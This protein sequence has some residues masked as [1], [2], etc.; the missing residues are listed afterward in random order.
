MRITTCYGAYLKRFYQSRASL[1]LSPYA[2]Q[3]S[4]WL[5]DFYGWADV[6]THALQ[7]F[8]YAG[9]EP[10]ANADQMQKA[11]AI[12]NDVRYREETWVFDILKAQV[13]SFA[14]DILFVNDHHTFTAP[15]IR[16]LR[17]F[18][19]SIRIIIG[20][21][22]AP[23]SDSSSLRACD[24]VLSNI[25]SL[26][27]R[28]RK[29]GM[30]AE[31]MHHAFDPR[32]LEIL[33]E[34]YGPP[35]D[36]S[37]VGSIVKGGRYHNVREHLLAKLARHSDLQIWTEVK[38]PKKGELRAHI[39]RNMAFRVAHAANHLP[40]GS[41]AIALIPKLR[42]YKGM[43][44]APRAAFHHPAILSRAQPAVFG[45]DMY[46][47]LRRSKLT[48]NQHI[49]LSADYASNMRL[50]EATGVG[51]CLLNERQSNLSELFSPDEEIVTYSSVEEITEKVK[52]LLN[53]DSTRLQIATAGQ[54]RTLESHTFA[55]R[56]VQMDALIGDILKKKT[57]FKAIA[58]NRCPS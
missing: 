34:R 56:A 52:Y 40:F 14:P 27:D 53:H 43:T 15:F 57:S 33:D 8:G 44:A 2:A 54:K 29:E 19:P 11:W 12:E 45:L 28:F 7:P 58:T 41:S 37:F 32:I 22:G 49:D 48:F 18:C 5:A 16:E 3:Y 21:C 46:R 1:A 9:W 26:V 25:P 17:E 47:T 35:I 24:V 50:F 23:C 30:C 6:W 38:R 31:Q 20:W 39:L 42:N 4:A 13:K 36:F 10:V 51:A 55:H